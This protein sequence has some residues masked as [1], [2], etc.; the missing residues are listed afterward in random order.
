MNDLAL[1]NT[2][3]VH[4]AMNDLTQAELAGLAGITRASVNAVE[5][6]RMVP[7][8]LLALKLA[9]ALGVTVDELFRIESAEEILKF[10]KRTKPVAGYSRR[11]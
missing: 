2:L 5:G 7:S 10:F 9:R 1:R 11:D 3:K 4:R 8:V 6:G